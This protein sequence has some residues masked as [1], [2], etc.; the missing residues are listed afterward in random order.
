VFNRFVRLDSS[1]ERSTGTTGLGLAIAHEIALVH[2]GHRAGCASAWS[3]TTASRFWHLPVIDHAVSPTWSTSG[4]C[5]RVAQLAEPTATG[6]TRAMT[7]GP[8][9]QHRQAENHGTP[10]QTAQTEFD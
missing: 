5:P 4:I 7:G 10:P 2:H 8:H 6:D 3:V 1:R 9:R